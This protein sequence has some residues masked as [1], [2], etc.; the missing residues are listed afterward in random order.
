MKFE[1][2][3]LPSCL[4]SS[5]DVMVSVSVGCVTSQLLSM[6]H[7]ERRLPLKVR[8]AIN[9]PNLCCHQPSLCPHR[10]CNWLSHASGT[11]RLRKGSHHSLAWE[12]RKY[13]WNWL[14]FSLLLVSAV[15]VLFEQSSFRMR[16][17][18]GVQLPKLCVKNCCL[19]PTK[20]GAYGSWNFPH[21]IST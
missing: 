9:F 13:F 14:K 12:I 18:W 20:S 8:H 19:C 2:T 17:E 10:A 15:S 21:M 3:S 4:N 16:G 7:V 6:N 11:L 5:A 1:P